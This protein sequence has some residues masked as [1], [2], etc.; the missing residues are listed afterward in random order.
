MKLSIIVATYN[1]SMYIED[2]IK[3]ILS[4]KTDFD[5]EILIGDDESDDG[6]TQIIEKYINLD[7]RIRLFKGSRKEVIYM[8]GVPTGRRNFFNLFNNAKGEYIAI[9]EGD[10]YWIDD[11]KLQ[12]Q[13]DFLESN[14]DY[15]ICFTNNLI[16]ING[17]LYPNDIILKDKDTFDM[18]DLLE[19]NFIHTPTVVL[20][21]EI[22]VFPDW[23][24]E[25]IQGDWALYLLT[26][27]GRKI[28]YLEDITS[29]YRIHDKGVY[30]NKPTSYKYIKFIEMLGII[31][32][33]FD[34][35]YDSIIQNIK[36][37]HL[38]IIDKALKVQEMLKQEIKEEEVGQYQLKV[39]S[40]LK[41][42]NHLDSKYED[43]LCL[44]QYLPEDLPKLKERLERFSSVYIY[45]AGVVGSNL[46]LWLHYHNIPVAGIIDANV[47]SML[48]QDVI[49]LDS[50]KNIPSN[51]L[52]IVSAN[53]YFEEIKLSLNK[54]KIYNVT[55]VKSLF[56]D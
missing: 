44:Y 9:C 37:H 25:V 8:D 17:K 45:G 2:N 10:D 11:Y 13:I 50:L 5:F 48:G 49:N 54:N 6:T 29:V 4:Q 28:K 42:N 55:N 38:H 1:H 15:A 23:Y 43:L 32:K 41:N 51:S 40:L 3:G 53:E 21:N 47:K 16:E 46:F 24:F 35:Q 31:N 27:K 12:K 7:N 22:D 39:N 14:K 33:H 36:N 34:Y 20:R 18:L 26:L 19:G 30:A 56:C 52:V